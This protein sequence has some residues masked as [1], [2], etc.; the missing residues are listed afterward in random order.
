MAN[1]T[2]HYDVA[3]EVSVGAVNQILAA[4]HENEDTR[5]PVLPHRMKRLVD[6]T[7]RGEGDPV[8]ASQRTGVEAAVE[9]Q[10]SSPTFSLPQGPVIGGAIAVARMRPGIWDLPTPSDVSIRVGVRAWVRG[11]P[12]PS[13]PEFLHGDVVVNGNVVKT[14]FDPVLDAGSI[15]TGFL[16]RRFGPIL[17]GTFVGLDR[18]SL[19]VSFL[20]AAG[21]TIAGDEV[22]R[23]Q[24]IIRN[25]L[26]ADFKPV[27]FQVSMPDSVRRWDYRLDPS[28]AS[29]RLMMVL[30]DRTLGPGAINSMSGGLVAPG[31]DFAM[32][33]GRDFILPLLKSQ[34]LQDMPAEFSFSKYR[35]RAKV[36]PNWAAA[37]FDL[38]PGR[39]VLTITG[40]GSISWWGVDDSFTFTIRLRFALAVVDGGLELQASGDPEVDLHDVAVGEGYIE[41]KARQRIREERDHALVA[42][43]PAIR[44]ALDV[45]SQLAAVLA[46][47]LP[48]SAAG[49]AITG[50]QIRTEGVLVS[51]R[52]N[53][54]PSRPVVVRHVRHHGMVDAVDSWVPGGRIDRFVWSRD[55]PVLTP[56]V[57][58]HG[59]LG[60]TSQRVEEHRFV[61]EDSASPV[62]FE[63][64]CLDVYGTR[65]SSGGGMVPVSGHTCGFTVPIPPWPL[66]TLPKKTRR[67]LP[68]VPLHGVR[69]DGSRAIVGHF[70]LWGS[71]RAPADGATTM[72]V[73]FATEKWEETIDD[74]ARAL[75]ASRRAA[76]VAVV[77]LPAG[78]E[79]GR[80]PAAV[81]THAALVVGEDVDGAWARLLGVS[82]TPATVVVDRRG[83][84]VFKEEAPLSR[85]RL[86][87]TLAGYTQPGGRVS[88]QPLQIGVVSGDLAPEFSFRAGGG[89]ELSLR[90]M[91]GRRVVLTF[92][93]SW[94][95]PSL[96]QLREF[97]RAHEYTCGRGPLVLAIGDGESADS[98]A[99]VTRE[100]RLPF[101]MI[102]DPAGALSRRFVVGVW[103]STVWIGPNMRV[104][105][106]SLGLT[107]I[108]G[109]DSGSHY[110]HAGCG[111]PP[112]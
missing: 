108:A 68:L 15:S 48:A 67:A 110:V 20:P 102:P 78:V 91:R 29:V 97:R 1:L 43:R 8:P 18:E 60:H 98:V 6:D 55:T 87:D 22:V 95:E 80:S 100:E 36:R 17:G 39:I 25:V 47:I 23:V 9:L 5:H 27:T 77:L 12:E 83:H 69:P 58:M 86:G 41:G 26:R 111:T 105:G 38:E 2:G 92:W 49:P 46:T 96:E 75:E 88:W 31:A 16:A 63:L 66:V 85:S 42:A 79:P 73:H 76:V 94:C 106:V 10:L 28:H 103:P 30:T 112:A 53:A 61:T 3:V 104:E 65:I 107:P 62:A 70:S 21:T 109:D 24:Q 4:V 84:I 90:R 50:V 52:I 11:S 72:V 89:A 59:G 13:I 35:V 56:M 51:G 81:D 99:R 74:L 19:S 101:I 71:G 57:A 37:T 54:A 82:K 7:P 44:D 33:I 40:N 14:T 93:A 45:K 32:A 64:R 34:V